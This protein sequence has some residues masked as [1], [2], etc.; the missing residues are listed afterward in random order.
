MMSVKLFIRLPDW[1]HVLPP[2]IRCSP[3]ARTMRALC[4]S[5]YTIM[6]VCQG[7]TPL[8]GGAIGLL[9]RGGPLPAARERLSLSLGVKA[10]NLSL[11]I[12]ANNLCCFHFL[13]VNGSFPLHPMQPYSRA[14][15]QLQV[16]R[17]LER[18]ELEFRRD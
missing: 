14:D 18:P 5:A 7:S 3:N 6:G 1:L 17:E 12:K 15:T 16:Q 11:G 8:G 4:F 2:R 9:E 13:W 10:N